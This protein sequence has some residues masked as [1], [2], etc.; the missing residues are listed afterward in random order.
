MDRAGSAM[1]IVFLHVLARE[2]R[3]REATGISLIQIKQLKSHVSSGLGP[4]EMPAE[5][6]EQRRFDPYQVRH[7][8]R[9]SY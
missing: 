1:W 9:A 5:S 7:R 2:E 4:I 6:A 3:Y 8:R